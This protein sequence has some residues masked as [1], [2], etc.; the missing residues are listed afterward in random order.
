MGKE[1][2]NILH[3][4]SE[5]SW[6]GGQQQVFYLHKGLVSA[7]IKS[8]LV[9]NKNSEIIERCIN[10]NLPY[11]ELAMYGEFDMPAAFK[12]S[13][14]CKREKINILQAHSAHALSIGIMTKLFYPSLILI[15]VRRVDFSVNKHIF[16]KLKY[17]NKRVN[18][19][20]CISDYIKNVLISDGIDK[21]KLVTVRSGVDISKFEG[22]IPS[23]EVQYNLGIKNGECLIGTVAAFAGHK[24]YPNLLKA[25]SIVLKKYS[26]TKL[27]I[28]GDG[29]LKKQVYSIAE[30]L[31]ITEN[32]IFAGFVN[33]VGEYLH[34]FDI[35]VLAS[36]KE[37]LG[38]S[39]IDALSVGLPVVTTKSGG[40]PELIIDDEN[41][42]LVE[43]QDPN[44]LA[45]A[46]VELLSNPEKRLRLGKAAKESS[47]QF[48]VEET[49]T[50]NICEYNRL[51]DEK[52]YE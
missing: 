13:K 50:Q 37:G 12:L 47:K 32:I 30:D 25:F 38:T 7:G 24:D 41:G 46:L 44:N 17:T 23:V 42:V 43:P 16:S 40:I 29:P 26:N 5:K 28:V 51:L 49:V 35:F 36:K 4:D 11:F 48:S 34:S 39:I 14:L 2:L 6:R 52:S 15:G 19:I 33:N 1:K 10:D 9:G 21:E 18:K 27:C 3:L 20:I 8:I 31:K 45:E 22:V